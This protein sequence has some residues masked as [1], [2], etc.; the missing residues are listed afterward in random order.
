M[1]TVATPFRLLTIAAALLLSGCASFS[2][3]GGQDAVRE[4]VNARSTQPMPDVAAG[5]TDT[6]IAA[7]LQQPLTVAG[8]VDIA[9]LNNYSL[10]ASYAELGIAEADLVQA[11]RLAN[12]VFSFGRVKNHHGGEVERQLM[13]PVIGL[14]TMP[15]TRKLERRRFAQAQMRAAGDALRIADETRR[16]WYGAVAA[17]QTAQYLEQ[18]KTAAEAS[19]ELARRMAEAGNWSKLQHAR[20]QA[21][22]ADTVAQLARARQ[23]RLAEREKLARLMGVAGTQASFTLPERLPDL[24]PAARRIEAAEAAAMTNR[25]DILM[26]S[27]ELEGLAASL[28]LTRATRFINLLDLSYLYNTN[29]EGERVRGYEVELQI[30]IF[31]WGSARVARAE[32]S[33]MQAAHRAAAI[34]LDARSQVRESYTG[35]LTAYD[36]ARHYRDEI[37]PLKKRISDEQ[38]LRYNGM[39]ISVFELLADAREQVASVN[40]AIEA[41]RDFWMADSAL[42]AAMTG[43]TG[44]QA[45]SSARGGAPAAASAPAQH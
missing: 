12:P 43:S 36:I 18:V 27:K 32:A 42:H 38:L 25:I 3:D 29:E 8:A 1:Q 31:D 41:Q 22:Y 15:I 28:G 40:A 11:G 24:P 13:V 23:A 30:P 16:A 9:M 6:H 7:L 10:K 44:V 34:A 39:L 14:L 21:F 4:L 5:A 19:A 26:A 35:Y 2:N 45:T 37:V 20:E 17:A 33:Y